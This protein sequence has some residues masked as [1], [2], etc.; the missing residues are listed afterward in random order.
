M[1]FLRDRVA[2][3]SHEWRIIADT[4]SSTTVVV[5]GRRA[6]EFA[7]PQGAYD[8]VSSAYRRV[9]DMRNM[10]PGQSYNLTMSDGSTKMVTVQNNTA[11]GVNVLDPS[12]GET[13]TIPH[14]QT[15]A[16]PKPVQPV[17]P[18]N[19]GSPGGP[20]ATPNQGVSPE[21][22]T[23]SRMLCAGDMRV[24]AADIGRE[25]YNCKHDNGYLYRKDPSAPE[26]YCAQC[27][28]VYAAERKTAGRCQTCGGGDKSC[29]N[30][31]G[32]PITPWEGSWAEKMQ[33]ER[34]QRQKKSAGCDSDYYVEGDDCNCD[35]HRKDKKAK[36]ISQEKECVNC[37][38]S[39][40]ELN[41][42]GECKKC[43]RRAMFR[44]WKNEERIVRAF[45]VIAAQPAAMP[46]NQGMPSGEVVN[47]GETL[48]MSEKGPGEFAEDPETQ[49]PRPT[50]PNA[51]RKLTPHEIIEEAESLIRNGL[52]KGIKIGADELQE[53]MGQYYNN[54]IEELMQG[55]ALAWQKVQYEE[56]ME[57]GTGDPNA[58][59]G[60]GFGPKPPTS[61][62]E[63]L[64][65]APKNGPIQTRRLSR[66][67]A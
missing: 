40:R 36:I 59:Q 3:G 46:Q 14:V 27:G 49:T 29:K 32:K 25:P 54:G 5:D 45:D 24:T 31:K 42:N 62:E 37:G 12:S 16:E 6:Y 13:M 63:A 65:Q 47:E 39:G 20:T 21:N 30:C 22:V 61:P 55:I 60:P 23:S 33:K 15:G 18:N 67:S 38:A 4:R 52:V 43:Q 66:R 34:E 7:S 1:K 10:Q 41:D 17:K 28:M 57:R 26:K 8:F 44:R 64:Q 35:I 51:K 2:F 50:D 56:G 58:P 11:Q 19:A 9:A 53:Y 48:N